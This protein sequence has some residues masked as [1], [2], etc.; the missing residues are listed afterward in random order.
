MSLRRYLI[1]IILFFIPLKVSANVPSE[2]HWIL[3]KLAQ[4]TYREV[5][6]TVDKIA[7]K[8]PETWSSR[9]GT[10]GGLIMTDPLFSSV[11][12]GLYR[13]SGQEGVKEEIEKR[14]FSTF[15]IKSQEMIA[16]S[17]GVQA[18]RYLLSG[19]V[20]GEQTIILAASIGASDGTKILYFAEAPEVWF[21]SYQ[22][23]F[24]DIL[25]SIR[26]L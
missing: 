18:E 6:L 5:T 8:V 26:S 15:E 9:A 17:N 20:G 24:E 22:P 16:L 1:I 10:S 25:L 14:F 4:V 3:Q 2:T 21:K 11:I 13:A 7:L 12:S 19:R 23:V